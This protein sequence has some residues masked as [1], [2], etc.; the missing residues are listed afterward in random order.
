[1]A[2]VFKKT[3]TKP[4]PQGA[5]AF[6]RKGES[7]ARWTD[8]KGKTRTEK[9]TTG[10]DGTP[11][12]LIE[13]DTWTA[14]FRDGAGIIREVATGCHDETAA[15]NVLAELV[16]RRENVKSG[17]V[18]AAQD[19]VIDFQATPISGHVDA[20]LIHLATKTSDAH[21]E[22]V[23]R[24]LRRIVADCKFE[25]LAHLDRSAVESWMI[26]KQAE[27]MGA[28]TRNTH[29]AA[30]IAF[31]N[32]CVESRR[33]A[34]NPLARLCKADEKA[35]C[36]RQRRALT[37]QELVALLEVAQRR[38]LLDAMTIRRG[39][40]K[41]EAA[42]KLKPQTVAR[43]E[44]LGRERGLTYK[45]L[46]L[47]GLRK[48]ELASLTVGQLELDGPMPHATLRAADE[49]N[50]QGSKIP[51]RADLAADLRAWL[52]DKLAAAQ[53]DALVP[54]ERNHNGPPT[55]AAARLP[56]NTPLFN[57][58][59]A[60]VLIL[61]RDMAMAGIPKVDERGRTV[62]VHALRTTTGTHLSKAGVTPRTAQAVMRHSTLDLTMNTYTDPRLLDVAGALDAL[63]DL[64][65]TNGQDAQELRKTGTT[66]GPAWPETTYGAPKSAAKAGVRESAAGKQRTCVSTSLAPTLAP[67]S[68][69]SST[70]G[71][72]ADETAGRKA[73]ASDRGGRAG[74]PCNTNAKRPQSFADNGRRQQRAKGVEPSTASLE[75]WRSSH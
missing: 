37:E 64:P 39:E 68:Y 33:L 49:K 26:R 65:L 66:G 48:G 29:R 4:L 30:I 54:T 75:G 43:L 20:Y 11:R 60:L 40:H 5:E 23:A 38:P 61:D 46:V 56:A 32:W 50:R 73:W 70:T 45:T 24:N 62:D 36:R 47:T 22:N 31:G 71:A 59:A 63:P 16:K 13:A 53:A 14:K 74:N 12:L 44:M 28:R 67:T 3:F 55:P 25:R 51:L 9:V 69:K 2:T 57:V 1:M 10:R 42:A 34:V 19:A 41:G 6:T 35:D 21:R 17:I 18:T 27:G 58:P 8:G 7:F 72:T 52:A 15:R